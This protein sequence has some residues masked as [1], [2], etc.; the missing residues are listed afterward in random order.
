MPRILQPWRQR[1]RALLEKVQPKRH[2]T[3]VETPSFRHDLQRVV[4][5]ISEVRSDK[6][7][8][9]VRSAIRKGVSAE[10]WSA[11]LRV[12]LDALHPRDAIAVLSEAHVT[13]TLEGIDEKLRIYTGTRS[14]NMR[15]QAASKEPW[16]YQ[17][18][19]AAIR[20][21][22]VLYDIGANVGGYSLIALARGAKVVAFEPHHENFR[23]LCRNI[24]LNRL[25]ANATLVPVALSDQRGA[26]RNP[27]FSGA[28]GQSM[29]L[30]E[31]E[32]GPVSIIADRLDDMRQDYQLP[33]P[34]HI[35][36]DVDGFEL[37]VLK[38]A[39]E[40]FASEQLRTCL[41]EVDLRAQNLDQD[42][43]RGV[44]KFFADHGFVTLEVSKPMAEVVHYLIAIREP[45]SPLRAALEQ[46][47]IGLK[48]AG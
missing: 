17:W 7:R 14:A 2:R 12:V 47:G 6:E 25:E 35:K 22:E 27:T 36:I 31:G 3:I 40:T 43:L 15:I 5:T 1:F 18:I 44:C 10:Q 46:S 32:S 26:L 19:R 8:Q 29:T 41:I 38:G 30:E 24:G 28:A 39:Q 42:R 48:T 21:G 20:P 37:K 23:E 45:S 4:E 33:A 13:R 16:T 9:Q 34:N 11:A